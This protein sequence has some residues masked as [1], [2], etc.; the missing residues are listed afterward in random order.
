MNQVQHLTQGPVKEQQEM[1][2]EVD[3]KKNAVMQ[4]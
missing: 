4:V 1:K 2:P 3:R